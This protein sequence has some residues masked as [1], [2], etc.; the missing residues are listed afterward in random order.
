MKLSEKLDFSFKKEHLTYF[1]DILSKY[2]KSRGDFLASPAF[3]S[4]KYISQFIAFQEETKEVSFSDIQEFAFQ[5]SEFLSRDY[6][7]WTFPTMSMLNDE[8]YGLMFSEPD[9]NTFSM[10]E[11]IEINKS[12]LETWNDLVKAITDI[13]FLDLTSFQNE[14]VDS[15]FIYYTDD[16]DKE[17]ITIIKEAI[18]NL[19]KTFADQLKEIDKVIFVSPEYLDS[20]AEMEDTFA[21]FIDDTIFVPNQLK[22]EDFTYTFFKE[23]FYHE[24]GHFI[25]YKIDEVIKNLWRNQCRDWIQSGN[26][27]FLRD[28]DTQEMDMYEIFADCFAFCF[29][30]DVEY[31]HRPDDLVL[32]AFKE[33]LLTG[34]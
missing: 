14:E 27:T 11:E 32:D 13:Y 7:I 16:C 24:F 30:P 25:Q 6:E 23:A 5:I 2:V 18:T 1:S 9:P 3:T 21:Y 15:L 29:C 4:E 10:D 20:S 28:D 12:I 31:F 34:L 33:T 22:K 17:L 19:R 26:V 8:L